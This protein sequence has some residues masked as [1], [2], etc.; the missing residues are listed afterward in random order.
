MTGNVIPEID[1]HP[2][3]W[4]WK[5][6]LCS[7]YEAKRTG[8]RKTNSGSSTLIHTSCK[9]TG[10]QCST[11]QTSGCSFIRWVLL[12]RHLHCWLPCL[13]CSPPASILGWNLQQFG[14]NERK[15]VQH[16]I[17][18]QKVRTA[19]VPPATKRTSQDWK[20][21]SLLTYEFSHCKGPE[22]VQRLVYWHLRVL[23][24]GNGF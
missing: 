23:L 8:L 15:G 24:I 10:N 18:C 22:I 3:A 2:G 1:R 6:W 21:A 13:P 17:I 16:C 11:S 5:D 14:G 19:A 7:N 20:V 12:L 9:E 4:H